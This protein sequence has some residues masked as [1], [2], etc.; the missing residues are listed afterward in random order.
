VGKDA[1]SIT[2]GF[3]ARRQR[4]EFAAKATRENAVVR[5]VRVR[6]G[7]PVRI[8]FRT[9]S[10]VCFHYLLGGSQL[11]SCGEPWDASHPRQL[12]MAL[13]RNGEQVWISDPFVS[14]SQEV[15]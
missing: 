14:S 7:G 1:A 5:G 6:V 4:T 9:T 11:W 2:P 15:R 13:T 10:T 8:M 12:V 3:S